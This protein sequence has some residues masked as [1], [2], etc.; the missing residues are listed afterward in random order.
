MKVHKHVKE[1]ETLG[2]GGGLNSSLTPGLR[3]DTGEVDSNT[4]KC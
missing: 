4:T 3:D 2:S 1:T